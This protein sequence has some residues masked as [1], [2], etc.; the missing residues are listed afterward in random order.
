MRIGLIIYESIDTITGGYIYDKKLVDYLRSKGV[1]VK[2]FSQQRTNFFSS[3]KHNFSNK[4]INDII[5]FSPDLLLQDEMNFVSLFLL[6]K[7]LKKIGN[8]PIISIVH[9]LNSNNYNN[10]FI[11]KYFI[12]KIENNYLKSVTGFIFNSFSTKKSVTA[13]IGENKPSLIAYPGKDRFNFRITQ[14]QIFDKCS[15]KELQIIFIG[16]LMYRKGLHVLIEALSQ[17]DAKLWRLSIIGDLHF[18]LKYTNKILKMISYLKL[19]KNMNILGLL[20]IEKLKKEISSHHVLAVPS[21]YES[22]G[23]VYAEVMGAGLP[24][25]ACNS[26]GVPEIVVDTFN[27]F[28][29]PPGDIEKVR[30]SIFRLI[31]NRE[32]LMKMSHSS[33]DAYENLLSWNETMHNVYSFLCQE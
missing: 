30:D 19:K 28:L 17:I 9:L 29:V 25:I 24:I 15:Y 20:D 5:Q 16:N 10:N 33:L 31:K 7:K 23:M 18:D 11:F 12:R 8:F 26:G 22:F 14:E 27:G 32:L 6:N 3:I 1:F 4:I 13:I 21:Y 2:I